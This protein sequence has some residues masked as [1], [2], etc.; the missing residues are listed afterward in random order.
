[1]SLLGERCI[2]LP[3]PFQLS[4]PDVVEVINVET[5]DNCMIWEIYCNVCVLHTLV[6]SGNFKIKIGFLGLLLTFVAALKV[7]ANSRSTSLWSTIHHAFD[8][9]FI[10]SSNNSGANFL[11]LC[12]HCF[13]KAEIAKLVHLYFLNVCHF[14]ISQRRIWEEHQ[15]VLSCFTLYSHSG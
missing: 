15:E 2:L 13:C 3:T 4:H 8:Q 12:N 11:S 1:M 6:I 10:R 7:D 5:N 14:R 9:W